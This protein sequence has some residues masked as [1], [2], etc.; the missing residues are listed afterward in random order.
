[1]AGYDL[2]HALEM[3]GLLRHFVM[4]HPGGRADEAALRTVKELSRRLLNAADD[5]NCL[6]AIG[7]IEKLAASVFSAEEHRRWDR[8]GQAGIVHL[9]QLILRELIGLRLRLRRMEAASAY[10][11]ANQTAGSADKRHPRSLQ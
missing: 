6:H 10:P 5:A 2:P 11:P 7:R 1:M 3:E 9:K 4:N 8:P